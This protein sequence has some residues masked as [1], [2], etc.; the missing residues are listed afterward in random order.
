MFPLKAYT[1]ARRNGYG[2]ARPTLCLAS[3]SSHTRLVASDDGELP[4]QPVGPS[5]SHRGWHEARIPTS[6]LC[7]E[8]PLEIIGSRPDMYSRT[9]GVIPR[10]AAIWPRNSVSMAR[11][12]HG[13]HRKE[14]HFSARMHP[15]IG[16]VGSVRTCLLRSRPESGTGPGTRDLAF[17]GAPAMSTIW[18]AA[19]R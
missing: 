12:F 2:A 5:C 17:T 10:S 11:P 16:S 13:R 14:C 18:A 6:P 7:W 8:K 9:T 15:K 3:V 1:P 4:P 19:N